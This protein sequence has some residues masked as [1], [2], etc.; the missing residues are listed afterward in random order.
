MGHSFASL[1]A[2]KPTDLEQ[3]LKQ[4]TAPAFSSIV[5]HEFRGWNVFGDALARGFG[6]A[7]G[8]QR[9]AKGF[10]ARDVVVDDTAAGHKTIDA[11]PFIEGYNVKIQ[12]GTAD[13]PWTAIPDDA[14]P[15]RHSFFRVAK[16]NEGAARLGRHMTALLLDYSLGNPT[17]G[18]LEGRGL[19]DFVVLPDPD[20]P[21]LLLGKAYM[22]IGPVTSAVGF[23]VAERMRRVDSNAWRPVT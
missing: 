13:E 4:G 12:R 1:I 23:F 9:F 11:L 16:A 17:P 21:D 15:T 8:I 14:A 3:L 19:R 6:T 22:T 20:N 7:M 5:S 10:F 2:L 18:L